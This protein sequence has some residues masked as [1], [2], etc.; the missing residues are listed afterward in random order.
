MSSPKTIADIKL[1]LLRPALTSHFAVT[2][3]KPGGGFDGF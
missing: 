3:P 2:I 1:N